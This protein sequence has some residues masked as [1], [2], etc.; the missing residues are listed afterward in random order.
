MVVLKNG[1]FLC[2]RP[3]VPHDLRR[4]WGHQPRERRL[5]ALGQP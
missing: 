2:R 3:R 4:G 5:L 1:R